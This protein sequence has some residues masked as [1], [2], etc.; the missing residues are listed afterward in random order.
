M[1]VAGGPAAQCMKAAGVGSVCYGVLTNPRD[2]RH[3]GSFDGRSVL[4]FSQEQLKRPR[5]GLWF[6]TRLLG[7]T[8]EGCFHIRWVNYN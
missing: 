4:R 6:G 8:H 7:L 1:C 3:I 2:F 5:K